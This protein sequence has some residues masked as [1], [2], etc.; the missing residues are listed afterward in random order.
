MRSIVFSAIML[1][2]AL[3]PILA[4]AQDRDI[5]LT[6]GEQASALS[7]ASSRA[8]WF[9]LYPAR[10]AVTIVKAAYQQDYRAQYLSASLGDRIAIAQTIGEKG[11]ERYSAAQRFETLLGPSGRSN[12]IGPD[13]VYW[14]GAAG[15]IRVLEAKG[16]SSARKWTYGSLQGTNANAIRS[17]GGVLVQAGASGGEKLH[18]ARVI[19]AAQ[20]GHLETSVVR[21]LHTQGTP[22]APRRTG[23]VNVD[24]VAK[25]AQQIERDLVRRNPNLGAVFRKAGFQH[26][27]DRLNYRGTKWL[28]GHDATS[29]FRLPSVR[30]ARLERIPPAASRFS[31]ASSGRGVLPQFLRIGSRWLLPVGV[32]VASVTVA[33]AYYQLATN[34]ISHREFLN[35]SASPA[36]LLAFTGTG[37]LIGGL[38]FGIG[39]IPG[40]AIGTTLAIPFQL[41]LEWVKY[42]YYRD[43]NEAQQEVVDKVVEVM[44][45]ENHALFRVQ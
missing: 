27:M 29:G 1:L 26:L 40:A 32:G 45:S 33:A 24:D 28:P 18:A 35:V 36:V 44:Y 17:A 3:F 42:R 30:L 38:A 19:K 5:P 22:H 10:T 13:S 31:L 34:S 12:P 23:G 25:E 37:A 9:K 20:V 41:G 14:N 43:F 16:G 7:G 6:P 4:D 15:K 8:G 11:V 2:C 39:A 21:T